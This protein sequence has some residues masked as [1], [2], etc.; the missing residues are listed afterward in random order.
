MSSPGHERQLVAEFADEDG[1]ATADARG[2]LEGRD[3]AT[4]ASAKAPSV[5]GR[6]QAASASVSATS[7]SIRSVDPRHAS[8]GAGRRLH[9]SFLT[10]E[11]SAVKKPSRK[12]SSRRLA[13]A[14]RARRAR[15]SSG[16]SARLARP[17]GQRRA[18]ARRETRDRRSARVHE[19]QRF[20]VVREPVGSDAWH[21]EQE[22]SRL[23]AQDRS[24]RRSSS[25]PPRAART[26]LAEHRA[27]TA[28]VRPS[29][30]ARARQVRGR[31]TAVIELDPLLGWLGAERVRHHFA[32]DEV[33]PRRGGRNEDACVARS[34]AVSNTSTARSMA[35]ATGNGEST[36]ASPRRVAKTSSS[37]APL[38]AQSTG[39]AGPD[40]D[41][42]VFDRAAP[43]ADR[44]LALG[45]TRAGRR[46]SAGDPA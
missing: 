1:G 30:R 23:Q 42:I 39:E 43:W 24:R 8:A 16:A 19:P 41:A 36:N 21:S 3:A 11:R 44:D 10:A 6:E 34:P 33:R 9:G 18:S 37:P 35:V 2:A 15:A 25:P 32:E 14:W 28:S 45:D 38:T 7:A 26:R 27:G 46:S 5:R 17:R 13:S 20:A 12:G 31:R 22:A 4:P 40:T 29:R